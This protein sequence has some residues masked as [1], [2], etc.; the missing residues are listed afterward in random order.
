MP[1]GFTPW[2]VMIMAPGAFFMLGIYIWI[3]RAVFPETV[4]IK[5]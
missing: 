2:T 3:I 4:E 5:K 1:D